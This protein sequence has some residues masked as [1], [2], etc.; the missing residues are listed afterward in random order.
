MEGVCQ[1][2]QRLNSCDGAVEQ[3]RGQQQQCV[4][5]EERANWSVLLRDP[6]DDSRAHGVCLSCLSVKGCKIGS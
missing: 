1:P 5:G 3:G 2:W 4:Y 6:H